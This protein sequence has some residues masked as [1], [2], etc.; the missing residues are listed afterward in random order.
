MSMARRP[1][2]HKLGKSATTACKRN[3]LFSS[4][5][6]TNTPSIRRKLTARVLQKKQTHPHTIANI[7]PGAKQ[8]NGRP[9]I[10]TLQ[11]RIH[12]TKTTTIDPS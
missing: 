3:H 2:F 10:F 7:I 5:T 12:G 1:S 8:R 4:Q 6:L 11:H 9:G